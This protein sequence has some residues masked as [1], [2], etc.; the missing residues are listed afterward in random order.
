[1]RLAL[2]LAAGG[3]VA[4]LLLAPR[5]ARGIDEDFFWDADPARRAA[6]GDEEGA[7]GVSLAGY[8]DLYRATGDPEALRQRIGTGLLIGAVAMG[9]EGLAELV[10]TQVD[11]YLEHRADLDP[12]GKFLQEVIEKFVHERLHFDWQT[13]QG[14]YAR[15]A[16]AMFL[17]ARGDTAGNDMIDKLHGQG[18]FYAEFFPYVRARHPGWLAVEPSI[19]RYLEKGDLASRV[20]AGTTL[21][22][23]YILFGVGG[24][25]W[26]EHRERIR[27]AF[28]EMRRRVLGFA[29]DPMTLGS[30]GTALLGMAMVGMLGFEKERRIIARDRPERYAGHA[31]LMK[32]ARVWI[33]VDGFDTYE[34]TSR[35]FRDLLPLAKEHYYGAAAHRLAAIRRGLIEGSKEEREELLRLLESAFDE[36]NNVTRALALQTLV[37]LDDERVPTLLQRAIDGRG[38][39]SIDAAA[40]SDDLADP[41]PVLLPALRTPEPDYSALAAVSLLDRG[42]THALQR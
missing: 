36:S 16:A 25:L 32:V 8:E 38:G 15:A 35:A 5:Y 14:F 10:Q 27:A 33:G 31:D 23:Y 9:Q 29:Q 22:N 4:S 1:M 2:I 39:F 20:E 34:Q 19:R 41:V 42:D 13:I 17:A 30:G 26:K 6:R 18:T 12:D 37:S 3:L 21:L 11:A 7:L 28:A 24:D 40:L